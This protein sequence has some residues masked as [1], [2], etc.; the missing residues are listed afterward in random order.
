MAVR[1]SIRRVFSAVRGAKCDARGWVF[2]ATA[3]PDNRRPGPA[4]AATDIE[5]QHATATQCR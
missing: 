3:D 1:M 2:I 4:S 5:R